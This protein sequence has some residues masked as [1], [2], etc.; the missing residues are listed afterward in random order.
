MLV[1]STQDYFNIKSVTKI[2][3]SEPETKQTQETRGALTQLINTA[4]ENSIPDVDAL[5]M[6]QLGHELKI[7]ELQPFPQFASPEDFAIH[8]MV[9]NQQEG[10]LKN[11]NSEALMSRL[12]Q[13][14][15]N[16]KNAYSN[17]SNILADLGQLGADQKSFLASS[18][19]HVM[20]TSANISEE[21]TRIINGYADD[22][23]FSISVKTKEGDSVVINLN[24]VQS[25]DRENHENISILELSYDVD[26]DLSD[27]EHAAMTEMLAGI[28]GLAD[29]YFSTMENLNFRSRTAPEFNMDFLNDFDNQQLAS[30]D[31][32][33]LSQDIAGNNQN[34][35]N[36]GYEFDIKDEQQ[37]LDFD[38]DNGQN[39]IAFNVDMSVYGQQDEQ[40]MMQYLDAMEGSFLENNVADENDD[41]IDIGEKEREQ[42]ASTFAIFKEIFQSMSEK[43]NE[44]TELEKIADENFMNGRELVS[45]LTKK[46]INHDPRYV[47]NSQSN[48]LGE[49]VSILAD[50]KAEFKVNA[51]LSLIH[52]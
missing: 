24:S 17:T 13:S 4:N 8:A 14:T 28:G 48:K 31:L 43:A 25:Y 11:E 45:E 39:Q 32:S 2:E 42:A 21:M 34:H 5:L 40:Q 47:E 46:V 20:N 9:T 30:F 1:A 37:T 19:R 33:F 44:F 7:V 29:E 10:L 49:G 26:G 38:F 18:E 22:N 36:V 52:I 12:E 41:R 50:F 51:Y 35:L 23:V 27:K 16:I 3:V 15:S 6:S